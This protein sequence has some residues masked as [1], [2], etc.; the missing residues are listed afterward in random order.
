[1]VNMSAKFDK[2]ICNG[3]VS[4]V[5]TRSMLGRTEPH[6]QGTTAALLYPHRNAGI[7]N[8][9]VSNVFTRSMLGRTE[10]RTHACTELQQPYY[11]PIATRCVGII[12]CLW[13]GSLVTNYV[14]VILKW[15]IYILTK[16]S[17]FLNLTKIGTDENLAIYSTVNCF[18]FVSTNF[19]QTA[20]KE[21]F[22]ST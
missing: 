15:Q 7:C 13:K 18:I 4:I 9:V 10:P 19:R 2:G 3:V 12:I 22:V 8:G 17:F 1:M 14:L 6:T 20:K 21:H 16:L 11:I 5:F